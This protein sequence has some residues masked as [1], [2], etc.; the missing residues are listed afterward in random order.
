MNNAET[1]RALMRDTP[2][3][4]GA[5]TRFLHWTMAAL[6]LWQFLAMGL[7][8][9]YGRQPWLSPI[10]AS[11]QPVGTILFLLVLLRI[12]WAIA[13]RGNR[14]AHGDGMLGLAA[15]AGHGLLYL[16]M[17][18]VPSLGLLRAWGSDRPF[19]P[20]GFE[21]FSAKTPPIEWTGALA[22]AL[23]GELAWTLLVLIAGHV[24][25]VGVHHAMWRDGTL[26]RMAGR[27]G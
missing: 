20:F 27:R 24:A 16:L 6:I 23:H 15:R 8:L 4:Y 18:V 10:V 5:V 13:N 1:P 22:D 19:A 17:L 7:R 9:V 25:M 14:P 2:R 21:I 12:A 11:H 26:A 3:A